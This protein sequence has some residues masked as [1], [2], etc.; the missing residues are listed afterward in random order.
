VTRRR[1]RFE[2]RILNAL[3]D[4]RDRTPHDILVT[5]GLTGWKAGLLYTA[6]AR[7]EQRGYVLSKWDAATPVGHRQRLYRITGSGI[8]W[9]GQARRTW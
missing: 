9:M 8:A 1:E 5:A 7:L 4:G 3:R 6:L 2:R